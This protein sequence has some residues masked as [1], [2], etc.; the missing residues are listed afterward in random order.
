MLKYIRIQPYKWSKVKWQEWGWSSGL[1]LD[2]HNSQYNAMCM[3]SHEDLDLVQFRGED[4][5]NFLDMYA[6][7]YNEGWEWFQGNWPTWK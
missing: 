1:G 6:K 3:S 2:W 7:L 4:L 5:I